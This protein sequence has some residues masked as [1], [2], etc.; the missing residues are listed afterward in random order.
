MGLIPWKGKREAIR[1][2]DNPLEDIRAEVE[3]MFERFF[4]YP[5]AFGF[6]GFGETSYQPAIDIAESE[7]EVLIRA[8]LPGLTPD[9]FQVD[10]TGNQLL[11]A[12]EKREAIESQEADRFYGECHFGRF[13]RTLPLPEGIDTDR[14]EAD[15]T[16]GVL[17]LRIP[18]L[19]SVQARKIK[20]KVNH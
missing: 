15:F 10:V 3:H 2:E 5:R 19:K 17:T 12:G 11:L 18:K 6:P 4:E 16:N 1:P 20:V 9:D 13:Q 14:A 7:R 8:E